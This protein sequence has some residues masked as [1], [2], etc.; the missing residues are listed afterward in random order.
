MAQ[1][2][3]LPYFNG[4]DTA[5]L[6]DLTAVGRDIIGK[7]TAADVVSYL[8][9]GTGRLLGAPKVFLSTGT[10][11]ST[12]ERMPFLFMRWVAAVAAADVRQTRQVRHLQVRAE[13]LERLERVGTLQDFPV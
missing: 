8:G 7:A 2:N 6:T 12:P 1:Q 11:T 10:Y 13:V 9:V 3:K 5:A 4:P